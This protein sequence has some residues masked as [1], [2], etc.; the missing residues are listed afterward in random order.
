MQVIKC[1][2][3]PKCQEAV[4]SNKGHLLAVA[5]DTTIAIISV[6]TF[7][8]L[9]TLIGHNGRILSLSWCTD[10]FHLVSAGVDGAIYQWNISTGKRTNEV[11]QKG[12]Q[13]RGVVTMQNNNI[14]AI[15]NSGALREI[16]RSEI[17]SLRGIDLIN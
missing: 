6:F 14:F 8:V 9:Q 4:F 17:V 12:I 1:Y 13:Y 11:V 16:C 5:Y 7:D 2:N 3:Y 15:T 10:D